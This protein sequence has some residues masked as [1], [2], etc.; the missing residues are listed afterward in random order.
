MDSAYMEG[1]ARR[2]NGYTRF[3]C[4][5]RRKLPCRLKRKAIMKRKNSTVGAKSGKET[6]DTRDFL[7][8]ASGSTALGFGCIGAV[9]ASLRSGSVGFFFAFTV[10]TF[11]AFVVGAIFGFCCWRLAA[12]GGGA[13]KLGLVLLMVVGM[14]GFLYPLRFTAKDKL[15][16]IALGLGVAA[17]VVSTGGYLIWRVA[18]FLEQ[19]T[20]PASDASTRGKDVAP[21]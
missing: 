2:A 6:V 15:P 20:P 16:A 3:L 8:I 4:L 21:K 7:R 12:K 1:R 5:A 19:E 10:W 9:L 13:A 14:G 18:R 17:V 11:V